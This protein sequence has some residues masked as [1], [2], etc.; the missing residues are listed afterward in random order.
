MTSTREKHEAAR[1]AGY[2]LDAI[3]TAHDDVERSRRIGKVLVIP[4]S[5]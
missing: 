1:A 5:V 3:A 2:P 4:D